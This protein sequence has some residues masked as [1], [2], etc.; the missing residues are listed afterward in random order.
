MN[1]VSVFYG[2]FLLIFIISCSNNRKKIEMTKKQLHQNYQQEESYANALE[3]A[4]FI[5]ENPPNNTEEAEKEFLLL[6]KLSSKW[7]SLEITGLTGAYRAKM[8]DI[9][10]KKD[11][12]K[13][14][15]CVE[16]GLEIMQKALKNYPSDIALRMYYAMTLASLPDVFKKKQEAI[17]SLTS[18]SRES[19][20]DNSKLMV[21][22]ALKRLK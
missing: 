20:S 22:D 5:L 15:E 6:N 4:K 14:V 1:K 16:E 19:L 2:I 9:Y 13:A 18:L 12:I 7:D 10:E 11:V 17:D 3:L 8:G 21:T